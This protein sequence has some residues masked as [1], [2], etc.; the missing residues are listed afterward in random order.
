MSLEPGQSIDRYVVE[1]VLGEGGLATI[2]LV[3]HAQLG[4]RHALKVM[5]V[6]K[7]QRSQ[8]L[9][10]EGRAQAQL[11]HP[12]VVN[13]TDVLEV[14]GY[15][16][17][18]MDY[19]PGLALDQWLEQYFPP[20]R[21]AVSMFRRIVDAVQAAHS[22]GMIHRDLK[23]ANVMMEKTPERWIPR[24]ADFG[25]VKMLQEIGADEELTR[26]G[27]G[28]GTPAYSAPEQLR[29]A[30]NVD[31]RADVFSLGCILYELTCG[32][33]AFPGRDPLAVAES[34]FTGSYKAP[35]ELRPGLPVAV[36]DT[37]HGCLDP[38]PDQRLADCAAIRASLRKSARRPRARQRSHSGLQ[39][40]SCLSMG[41]LAGFTLVMLIGAGA[42]YGLA[43]T[44][45]LPLG[46]P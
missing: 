27:V 9:L 35:E 22:V 43:I 20:V 33:R 21:E 30:R 10:Q 37:I 8:R 13:V 14:D 28:M 44:G 32:Q 31:E 7:S 36:V 40:A 29:D 16:A 23:P 42:V 46:A 6:P 5:N 3:R 12:N 4:R 11:Q 15:P 41:F 38:D 1:A 24:V 25:L 39:L 17:L 18:L 26:S 2:Y 34:V 45:V 19:V